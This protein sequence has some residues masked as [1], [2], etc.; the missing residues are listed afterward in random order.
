MPRPLWHWVLR[1]GMCLYRTRLY[2]WWLHA[3]PWRKRCA[4]W[5]DGE[6]CS[7]KMARAARRGAPMRVLMSICGAGGMWALCLMLMGAKSCNAGG[8]TFHGHH[9]PSGTL[10]CHQLMKLWYLA[11]GDPAMEETMAAIAMAESDGEQYAQSSIG[12]IGYWQINPI[13]WPNLATTDPLGNARAAK[14]ILRK[15][16]L[17]AWTTYNSGAYSGRC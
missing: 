15:Q 9:V 2:Q 12:A 17:G 8:E 16:G 4:C 10:N 6:T 11:G 1:T 7:D 14:I 13:T 3:M 5:D